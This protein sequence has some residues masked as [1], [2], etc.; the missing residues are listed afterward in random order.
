VKLPLVHPCLLVLSVLLAGCSASFAP[1]PEV[2]G[3]TPLGTLAGQAYGGQQPLVGA[4]I[5]AYQSGTGGYGTASKSLLGATDT[6]GYATTYDG[7]AYYVTTDA[8][9]YFQIGSAVTCTSKTVVYLFSLSGNPGSGANTAAGLMAVLGT[10]P[11][12]GTLIGAVTS[13]GKAQIYMNEVSTVAAAYALS[14]FATSATAISNAGGTLGNY[15]IQN[16]AANAAQMYTTIATSDGSTGN[17]GS[18][19][20]A[21]ATTPGGNGTVPQAKLDTLANILAACV[22]ST[23]PGSTACSGLFGDIKSAGTSGTTAT[24]TATAAIYIAHN[25]VANVT[26]LFDL[27]GSTANPFTPALSVAPH[28]F[29]VEL[30][31]TGGGLTSAGY[32]VHPIAF[33]SSGNAWVVSGGGTVLSEFSPLGVPANPGGYAENFDAPDAIAIDTS[34]NI[35]V[36]DENSNNYIGSVYKI[37]SSGTKLG[38]F[39]TDVD[40]PKDIEIDGSG[41][42]WVPELNNILEFTN[43]GAFVRDVKDSNTLIPY[44]VAFEPGAAGNFWVADEEQMAAYT[45]TDSGGTVAGS[46]FA[47]TVDLPICNA[48]DSGGNVWFVAAGGTLSKINA[49]GAP[50]NGS[51]IATGASTTVSLAIDGAGN[52]WVTDNSAAVREISSTGVN[53]STTAGFTPSSTAQ[54]QGLAIDGSGDVWYDTYNDSTLREMI[55]AATP[56]ATP[57]AYGVANSKLGTRP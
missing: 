45:Y 40:G 52:A 56:V 7:A 32:V 34:G 17:N 51:P 36:E 14:G 50:V 10:C 12:G 54:P 46:P 30:S 28:D 2:P 33:D 47:N 31:F 1:T 18:T 48:I 44:A 16:A 29:T 15:G 57:I 37:S 41:N 42:V 53:L 55:G 26:A 49:A 4:H 3:E 6:G 39:N 19:R 35:W 25:P 9:G 23:G 27:V 5:Y 38:T 8:N 21:L 20:A 11:A 22:N 24:N 43:S 13:S